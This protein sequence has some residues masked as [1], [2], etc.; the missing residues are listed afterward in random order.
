MS[1][2]PPTLAGYAEWGSLAAAFATIA[3]ILSAFLIFNAGEFLMINP[4]KIEMTSARTSRSWSGSHGWATKEAAD[5][6][7]KSRLDRLDSFNRTLRIRV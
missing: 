7:S 4:E 1:A 3:V 6:L 5:L 2:R